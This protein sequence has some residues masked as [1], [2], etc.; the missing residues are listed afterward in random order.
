MDEPVRILSDLHLGHKISRIADVSELRPLI[1][2][3]GTVIFNGDTWQ[4]LAAP[5]L[6]RSTVM[7]EALKSLC[8]EEG[9]KPIFLSGNHD[10]G[11]PGPGWVELAGGRIIITHGDALWFDGSPWK[12]EILLN[13]RRVME[14]WD[15]HPH[16]DRR[17]EERLR[18]ARKIAR[19]LCSVEYPAGRRFLQRAWDA[20]VP[21]QRAIKMVEGWLTQGTVGA[22]FC[23]NYFPRAEML[24]IGHF[25]HEGSWRRGNRRV[26]N[27]GSFM[28]PGRAHWL[29]WQDSWLSR[30]VIDESSGQC[31]KGK[32]LDVW[33]F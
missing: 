26:I 17:V 24:V 14:L 19:E 31:R 33:R 22:E 13:G 6:K 9:A 4:E 2:G 28:A 3:A 11:W 32:I 30:G 18:V 21:P 12:R 25:H 20:I 7:L 10:P 15:E 8:H 29:E 16:A 23:A 27:T 5:F 1:A